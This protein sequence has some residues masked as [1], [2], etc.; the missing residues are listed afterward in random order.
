MGMEILKKIRLEAG[1]S[2][3]KAG[4]ADFA[5]QTIQQYE[6]PDTACLQIH[7]LVRLKRVTGWSWERIG[8]A[9]EEALADGRPEQNKK[10]EKE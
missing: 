10:K 3:S 7:Y 4:G 1:L 2:R 9:L 6:D 5:G 8:K